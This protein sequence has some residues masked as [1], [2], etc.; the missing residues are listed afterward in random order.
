MSS[1]AIE[2]KTDPQTGGDVGAEMTLQPSINKKAS[3]KKSV[4]NAHPIIQH[5][6][7]RL[8]IP[9]IIRSTIK[10]DQRCI[11]QIEQALPIVIHNYLTESLPLYELQNWTHPLA[12]EALGLS[13][14]EHNTTRISKL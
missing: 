9:E 11:V 1:I 10:S 7:E 14:H 2:R 8:R 4:L 5:Y 6:I 12:A 13:E 3:L